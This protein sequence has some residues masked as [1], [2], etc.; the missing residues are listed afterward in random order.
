M[1]AVKT[2]PGMREWIPCALDSLTT[3]LAQNS[4]VLGILLLTLPGDSYV[5]PLRF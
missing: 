1:S 5:V 3:S 2:G 4:I